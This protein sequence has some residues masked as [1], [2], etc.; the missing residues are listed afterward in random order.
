MSDIQGKGVTAAAGWELYI[1]EGMGGSWPCSVPSWALMLPLP[2]DSHQAK[3]QPKETSRLPVHPGQTV[4]WKE[5]TDC[6]EIFQEQVEEARSISP[7]HQL[8][9]ESSSLQNQSARADTQL[10]IINVFSACWGPM[11]G[12]LGKGKKGLN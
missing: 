9:L 2:H 11:L 6:P 1:R 4:G 3:G 10:L 7:A 5:V 8:P 12:L